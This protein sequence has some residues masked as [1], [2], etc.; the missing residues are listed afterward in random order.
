MTAI[1]KRSGSSRSAQSRSGEVIGT[2]AQWCGTACAA[3]VV[4]RCVE[5]RIVQ[6]RQGT[7]WNNHASTIDVPGLAYNDFQSQAP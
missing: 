7:S 6:I 4:W 5:L 3:A 1:Y 2:W